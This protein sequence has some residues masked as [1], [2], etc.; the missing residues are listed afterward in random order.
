MRSIP[1]SPDAARHGSARSLP[2]FTL[3]ELLVVIAIIAILIGL[4]LPAVQKVREA[5]NRMKC[6]NNLKQIV[7]ALH[8]YH[9]TSGMFPPSYSQWSW[10]KK[11]LTTDDKPTFR[12]SVY[13]LPYIEQDNLYKQ[14]NL[15]VSSR[16]AP[17]RDYAGVLIKTYI[18]PSDPL[19]ERVIT[20]GTRYAVDFM[21]GVP[22]T[23]ATNYMESGWVW[24]CKQDGKTPVGFC[25]SPGGVGF[26]SDTNDPVD[27]QNGDA[28]NAGIKP[29]RRRI[30]DITDGTSNTIAVAESLPD[31][32]NWSSWMYGDTNNFSTSYGINTRMK[33]C[34]AFLGGNWQNWQ[35]SRGFKSMHTGGVNAALADASVHFI[36]ENIDMTVFQRLGTIHAGDLAALDE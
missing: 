18:C 12:W 29:V 1:P 5:A 30:A 28:W 23:S 24:D 26:A 7:L 21:N 2:A 34:C 11:P 17:N 20:S 35:I 3:I 10:D 15:N 14:L 16:V 19:G 25:L 6:S 4:L 8:N 36:K 32:Y 27:N 13:L 33:D 31:C 9:D 22:A